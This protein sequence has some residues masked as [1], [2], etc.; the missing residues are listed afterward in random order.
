MKNLSK[1]GDIG[2]I[3]KILIVVLFVT[4]FIVI[5]YFV[6]HT[7]NKDLPDKVINQN[8]DRINPAMQII[9]LRDNGNLNESA[10]IEQGIKYFNVSYINYLLASLGTSYLHKPAIGYGNPKLELVID[11]EVWS[12]ELDKG[13]LITQNI[14]SDKPDLRITLSKEVAV[15]AI[16]S[17]DVK[18]YMKDSVSNGKVRIDMIAGKVELYAKGYLDMSKALGYDIKL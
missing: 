12:T 8:T 3:I 13:N 7:Q 11:D 16:L 15:R 6:F 18:Q 14:A 2:T 5:G 4:L 10:T 9:S 1:K 17:S